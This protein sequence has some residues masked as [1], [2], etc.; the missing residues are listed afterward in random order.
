MSCLEGK[1][2]IRQPFGMSIPA[3]VLCGIVGLINPPRDM[4]G[5]QHGDIALVL[6]ITIAE[7]GNQISLF[8]HAANDYP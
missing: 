6:A 2:V 4:I 8:K 7:F 5:H 1:A 3:A